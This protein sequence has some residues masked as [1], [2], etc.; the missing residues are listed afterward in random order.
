MKIKDWI[1]QEVITVEPETSVKKAFYLMKS[2]G[3]RH[4]PVV[5]GETLKG[6]V[7]DRDLRRPKISDV[8][9][10]WD[11]LYRIN[12]EIDVEDVMVTPVAT[13]PEEATIQEAAKLLVEKR[14]GAIP[15]TD[16]KGKMVGIITESD[17]LRA[18]VAGKR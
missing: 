1:T 17:I 3:I 13:L 10:S 18:F 15:V 9:K 5:R 14:I 7:T 16:K 4:L 8:F 6:I 12:D 2:L 11:E